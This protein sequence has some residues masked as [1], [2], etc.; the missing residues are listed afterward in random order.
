MF[1]TYSRDFRCQPRAGFQWLYQHSTIGELSCG[2]WCVLLFVA[3]FLRFV[4]LHSQHVLHKD[5]KSG[6]FKKCLSVHAEPLQ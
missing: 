6:L 2:H 3:D 1:V 5:I 4:K